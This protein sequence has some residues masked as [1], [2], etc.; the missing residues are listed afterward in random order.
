VI[1]SL[2]DKE[3]VADD[4]FKSYMG[5]STA[6]TFV[7]SDY[8]EFAANMEARPVPSYEF[9]AEAAAEIVPP[10]KVEKAKSG[11][12]ACQ[13]CRDNAKS[14][15]AREE[16]DRLEEEALARGEVAPKK[17]KRVKQLPLSSEEYLKLSPIAKDEV[18]IGTMDMMA[19]TYARFVHVSCWRVPSKIWLGL[20]DPDVERDFRKF[21]AGVYVCVCFLKGSM[22]DFTSIYIHHHLAPLR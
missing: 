14:K 19:G 9:F 11:R 15:A 20:P 10:Y 6:Q 1:R 8:A 22:C 16:E 5:M 18:R 3:R 17:K 13:A 21:A 2:F 7:S 12:S 4:S